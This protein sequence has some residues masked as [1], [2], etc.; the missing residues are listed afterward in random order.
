L[1]HVSGSA[2]SWMRRSEK[3]RIVS[4]VREESE[5]TNV[6]RLEDA[7]GIACAAELKK[8]LLQ[9]LESGKEVSVSLEGATD[10]DVTAVQ[11]LWAAVRKKRK[12]GAGIVLVGAMPETLSTAFADAGFEKFLVSGN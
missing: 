10:L 11:L 4:L 5:A 2:A 9:A 1:I 6:I 8:L 7:I 3:E 12:S